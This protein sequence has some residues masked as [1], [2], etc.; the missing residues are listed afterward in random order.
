MNI[1]FAD[2]FSDPGGAQLCLMDLMPEIRRRGWNPR[3]I[4]P[5]NGRLLSQAAED[6]IATHPL[7]L[8]TYTN[9]RKTLRDVVR[10]SFDLPRM[11]AALRGAVM[12]YDID[13]VY[14]NGPRVLPAATGLPCPVIFH[15]HSIVSGRAAGVVNRALRATKATVIAA[16]KFVAQHYAAGA[17]VIYN[18]VPDLN[19]GARSFSGGRFRVGILGR[20]APEKGHLDFVRAATA[21]ATVVPGAT[22]H[23]FGE[24]LFSDP[25]YAREVRALAAGTPVEFAGWTADVAGA[26]NNLDILVVPSGPSE[27]AT[28]VI[29]EAFS[30]GTP[31]VAYRSG[32]I[33]ELVE[34]NRTGLLAD[35]GCDALATAIQ[36]LIRNPGLRE[37]LSLAGR[38]EWRTRFTG[39]AFQTAVCAVV[40]RVASD[41]PAT[42]AAHSE[43]SAK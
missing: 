17:E 39:Q 29:M 43:A 35:A 10:F 6:G 4:A 11:R 22:F 7:P 34:H 28:R 38:E 26:L 9:G 16:S 23:V 40:A 30:A 20:I 31:V 41:S 21:V 8:G 13:L 36:S 25:R 37:R 24:S 12:L 33:P 18:G 14:V 27:A 2:Q 32:G 15:A 1:L 19:R 5:G 3:L 42:K